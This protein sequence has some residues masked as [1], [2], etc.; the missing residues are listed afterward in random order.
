[1]L[2]LDYSR[3]Q[4]EWVPNKDGGNENLEAVDFLQ[5][6]NA[7]AYGA[8]PGIMTIAEESTSW[9]GS[10]ADNKGGL[11]F[12]FKWNM[13][14]MNDTLRIFERAADPP[15]LPPQRHDL[16]G[17]LCLQRELRPAAEP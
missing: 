7:E 9:P 13:G 6:V 17:A 10:R 12:G 15:P 14:F 1:M 4:G 16:R 2:Y 3:K 8:H 5:R 11:G